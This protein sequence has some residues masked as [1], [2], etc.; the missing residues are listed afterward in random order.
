[1]LRYQA[2]ALVDRLMQAPF[3]MLFAPGVLL[4]AVGWGV[5]VGAALRH[6]AG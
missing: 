6:M 5:M 3:V 2:L 1:M 4:F